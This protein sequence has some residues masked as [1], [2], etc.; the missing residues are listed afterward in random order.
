MVRTIRL[1]VQFPDVY[2]IVKHHPRNRSAKKLTQKLIGMY[3]EVRQNLDRNLKFIY[4]GVNSGSLL[5]WADLIIDLGTSVTWEAVKQNKP[6][7]MIEYLYANHSTIAHYIKS[8]EIKCRDELYDTLQE[9]IKDKDRKFYDDAE[10]RRFI[11]EIID[12]PDKHVLERYCSFLE[13]CLN[14]SINKK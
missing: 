3:P 14:G 1:I 8:T 6:V 12:V 2:L 4:S 11:K 10:R 7:F 5:N 13:S 9:F